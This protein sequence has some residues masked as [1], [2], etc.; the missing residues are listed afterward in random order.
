MKLPFFL[1]SR[2]VAGE[3]LDAAL[4]QVRSLNQKGLHATLDLLGEYVSDRKVAARFTEVYLQ[5]LQQI[6]QT[7]G[8]DCNISMKLSMI[9]QKIDREFCLDNLHKILTVAKEQNIFVRLDMEGSDITQSTLDLFEKVYPKYPDHVGV[10][11]QAYL[12][13]TQEDVARMCDLKARVRLCKG[14]YREPAQIAYQDMPNIRERY[15]AYMAQLIN[16]ARYPGIATHDDYLIN[17]TKKY[18]A[19]HNI[20]KD[21]FEFQMLYGIR[22][23]TQEQIGKV[24][25]MRV[26]VP[27]GTEWLPYYSRRLRE[28]KENIWFILKNLLRG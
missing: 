16:E 28:R 7:P 5:L 9:G 13:R 24:Y 3:T 8:I 6:G 15:L 11:L 12:H 19:E 27:Y 20:G 22:P 25:N 23:E 21:R 18:V 26:Y 2:F 10:V 14:A 4:P 17:E 1:A